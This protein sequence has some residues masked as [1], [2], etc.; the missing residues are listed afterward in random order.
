MAGE[1]PAHLTGPSREPDRA[2]RGL[3]WSFLLNGGQVVLI[4]V[5]GTM[6]L[7]LMRVALVAAIAATVGVGP[8]IFFHDYGGTV[9]FVGFLFAFWAFAQRW[10]LI[11]AAPD[12]EVST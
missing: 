8:A 10:I 5:A 3:A 1:D 6:L 11:V 2:L 9:L 4:G 7:N 12:A